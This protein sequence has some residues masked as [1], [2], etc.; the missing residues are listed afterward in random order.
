MTEY[1]IQS[2]DGLEAEM[3]AVAPGEKRAPADAARASFQV[4][5]PSTR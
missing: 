1:K 2:L 3:R 5:N 4:F